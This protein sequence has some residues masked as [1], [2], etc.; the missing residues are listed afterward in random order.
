MFSS[1][2]V[3]TL[4]SLLLLIVFFSELRAGCRSALR[5]YAASSELELRFDPIEIE[6]GLVELIDAEHELIMF[7]VFRFY[8]PAV[9]AALIRGVKR[10]VE[11]K[12]LFTKHASGWTSKLRR[13]RADFDKHGFETVV[14]EGLRKYHAKY[15]LF[16]GQRKAFLFTG[17]ITEHHLKAS[18][19]EIRDFA[20]ITSD[21]GIYDELVAIFNADMEGKTLEI[22]LKHFVLAPDNAEAFYGALFV[23]HRRAS[24]ILIVDHKFKRIDLLDPVLKQAARKRPK[25]KLI[26]L[27]CSKW[28]AYPIDCYEIDPSFAQLHGKAVIIDRKIAVVSSIGLK[29]KNLNKRRDIALILRNLRAIDRLRRV[30]KADLKHSVKS[31]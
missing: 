8:E 29:E 13:I 31:E 1:I 2:R 7:P 28:A 14:F 23:E 5:T 6:D 12:A 26:T 19:V 21:P 16:G 22:A 20:V 15:F 10:G 27:D 25:V 3:S 4:I 24:E 9:R 30:F 17:N 18:A 11:V